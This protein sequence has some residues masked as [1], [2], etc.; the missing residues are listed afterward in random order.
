MKNLSTHILESFQVNEEKYTIKS[1]ISDYTS[2]VESLEAEKKKGTKTVKSSIY[3][4]DETSDDETMPI[5]D[6][7][8]IWKT[9]LDELK[10]GKTN[11][12]DYNY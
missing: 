11:P 2:E 12:E 4:L 1:A 9:K 7:I 3:D 6:A 5:D 10:S 8:K